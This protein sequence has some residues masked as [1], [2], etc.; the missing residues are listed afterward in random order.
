MVGSL[1]HLVRFTDAA[2]ARAYLSVFRER[3]A[4][5]VFLF[6][7]LFGDE[8]EIDQNAVDPLQRTTV[9]Q[10][11][12]VIQ[13]YRD[14]GYR[15]I[16]PEELLRDDGDCARSGKLAM[17]TFDDGYF[18]NTRALPVLEEFGI[19]A[20]FFIATDNVQQGK[21]FWWDVFYR[22]R[23]A[24]GA[25]PAAAH[26]EARRLKLLTTEQI[27][28]ELTEQFGGRHIFEPRGD[29]DRPFTPGQ[30]REFAAHRCVR[31]GNHTANHA[32]LTN[33]P[34]DAARQQVAQ[35]QQ[36]LREMTGVTA[37]AIAYPNGNYSNSVVDLCREVGLTL[38]FTTRGR[39]TS[40]PFPRDA[41]ER[42]LIGRFMT[43]GDAP[44][45]SQCKTYRSDVQLYGIM[46]DSFVRLRGGAATS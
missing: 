26:A 34:R 14:E 42:M 39:K 12:Q 24:R 13:Y 11:R 32:I 41:A 45:L 15:F 5:M 16:D 36:A 25:L 4:L 27:E 40:L 35:A 19:P 8:R 46:R 7:S 2:L 44:I 33:Y 23:V 18:N 6:H 31:L 21:C 1:Q 28:V 29:I 9:A 43:E 38:G 20:L 10:F 22:E 30:L 37:S 3:N 17:I